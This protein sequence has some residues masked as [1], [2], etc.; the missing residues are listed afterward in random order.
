MELYIYLHIPPFIYVYIRME[1]PQDFA[2]SSFGWTDE[3]LPLTSLPTNPRDT[4][5]G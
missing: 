1:R 4:S 5:R 2:V 3:D